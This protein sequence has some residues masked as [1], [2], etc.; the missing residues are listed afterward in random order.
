MT[1]G[2]DATPDSALTSAGAGPS[3]ET[4]VVRTP[5]EAAPELA[6]SLDDD[7]DDEGGGDC[8]W[9]R[10]AERASIVLLSA[11]ASALVVALLTWLGFYIYD[12]VK[13]TPPGTVGTIPAAALPPISSADGRTAPP[14]AAPPPATVTVIPAP[15]TTVTVQ[16]APPAPD[17]VKPTPTPSASVPRAL[18][19]HTD[20]FTI[21]PDGH[22]G[23]VG[24][25]TS[26]A[27]AANVRQIFYATG[28][29]N[30]FTAFSPITGDGYEM[31]CVGRYPAVF[32]DGST[33]ISTRCYGGDNAEVVIW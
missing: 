9:G 24:G 22:E 12:H 19:S 15:P 32:N 2:T 33:M 11:V 29:A 27:F 3:E 13:P 4:T 21:C 18:P 7:D 17:T 6:W 1:S 25:H 26:C 10:V 20:V 14:V 31:T 5:A 16:A 30:N 23:V 8:S 28:M